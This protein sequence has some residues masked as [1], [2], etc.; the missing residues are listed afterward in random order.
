VRPAGNSEVC[1]QDHP[2]EDSVVEKIDLDRE[3]E[4]INEPWR[5][6]VIARLNGQ[7]VKL[8]KFRGEFVWHTHETED[9]MFLG[10]HGHFMVEFRDR[11]VEIGPGQLIVVPRGVEHRTSAAEEA[12][13]LIFEPQDV[14]NTGD[15]FDERLTAPGEQPS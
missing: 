5:P 8:A 6:K 3:L 13:V 14:R 2:Q 10:V 12:D 11:R 1:R 9:E 4:L 7:E 15:I